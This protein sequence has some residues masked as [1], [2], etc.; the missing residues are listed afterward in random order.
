MVH[1]EDLP[2]DLAR[3]VCT[4]AAAWDHSLETGFALSSVCKLFQMWVDP[5]IFRHLEFRT[6]LLDRYLLLQKDP[7]SRRLVSVRP[8][9]WS[10]KFT[11]N[12]TL[13]LSQLKR[14]ASI[15]PCVKSL[16]IF[17]SIPAG[18]EALHLPA[19]THLSASFLDYT[20]RSI[21]GPL[22]ANVT[23]LDMSS[24]D[25]KD[26]LGVA[27]YLKLLP[28]LEAIVIG[29]TGPNITSPGECMNN[30]LCALPA[31]PSHLK[32]ILCFLNVH[33]VK[34]YLNVDE[35]AE[36]LA[37]GKIDPRAV[38]CISES[39]EIEDASLPGQIFIANHFSMSS[40]LWSW[41]IPEEETFWALAGAVLEVR[42]SRERTRSYISD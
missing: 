37:N 1:F 30:I 32:L 26:L 29:G 28:L 35:R 4:S 31:L 15:H 9:V 38:V 22:F 12:C 16:Y 5:L 2:V 23:H 7:V 24:L 8:Y 10:L 25:G 27:I 11:S 17:H 19:L 21:Y 33:S 14:L 42:R 40:Q 39:G 34:E 36:D 20:S 18:S 13:Q 3:L 6:V 41:R